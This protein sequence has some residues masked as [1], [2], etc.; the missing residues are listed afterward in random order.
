MGKCWDKP[1]AYYADF[2]KCSDINEI[3][4]LI[5]YNIYRLQEIVYKNNKKFSI[6]TYGKY[7]RMDAYKEKNGETYE[8]FYFYMRLSNVLLKVKVLLEMQVE[9][10][11]KMRRSKTNK[12]L[13]NNNSYLSD[14]KQH[15]D[16]VKSLL[17]QILDTEDDLNERSL[18]KFENQIHCDV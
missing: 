14:D 17:T 5:A 16:N 18:V 10:N 9:E 2:N 1:R 15:L 7:D 13:S 3:I 12:N 11:R 6:L 4:T 8:K